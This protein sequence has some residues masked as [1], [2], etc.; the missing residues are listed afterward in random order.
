M[1]TRLYAQTKKTEISFASARF[2]AT[3]TMEQVI[4]NYNKAMPRNN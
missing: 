1:P 4:E 3:D 2:F